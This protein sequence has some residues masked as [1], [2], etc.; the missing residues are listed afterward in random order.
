MTMGEQRRDAQAGR[1]CI[2]IA[3]AAVS[4]GAVPVA[5][6]EGTSSVISVAVGSLEQA[7]GHW[8]QWPPVL[9]STVYRAPIETP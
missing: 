6:V 1:R 2:V 4:E 7:P 9:L 8:S 5:N 3:M